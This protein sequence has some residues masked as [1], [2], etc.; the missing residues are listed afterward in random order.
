MSRPP[1]PRSNEKGAVVAVM[2]ALLLLI[3]VY[4]MFGSVNLAAVRVD[5]DRVTNETLR[6]AKEALIAY[7]VADPNRPGELPCPDV[8]NDGQ[9][10]VAADYVGSNC[11][12]LIG[13]LPFMTLGLPDLRDDSG[14]RLWYAVSDDF[15]ANGTVAL[16][17]DTA[18]RAG[19]TSLRITG[20]QSAN[21]LVAI[22]FAPGGVLQREGA[23]G[24][25]D[26]GAGALVAANYLDRIAGED[27]S[28][29]NRTFVAGPKSDSFNDKLMPIHSDEIMWLVERRAGRELTQHLRDQFDAWQTAAGKGFYPWAAPFSD[30]TT[31]QAGVANTLEGLLPLAPAPLVW[32][33][34]SAGCA[35]VGTSAI[36][37]T[38]LV[39]PPLIPALNING[40]IGNIGR[41]FFE[42]PKTTPPDVQVLGGLTLLGAPVATW[43]VNAPA[44]ALNFSYNAPGLGVGLVTVQVTAP[45]VSTWIGSSWLKDNHWYEVAY[46]GVAAPFTITGAGSCGSCITVTNT[47]LPGNKE[48]LVVMTGRALPGQ[49]ARP[50]TPPAALNQFLENQ[51]STSGDQTYEANVKSTTFND[52]PVVVRP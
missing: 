6:R 47:A 27:N 31:M 3:G 8:N 18:F 39:A 20:M 32:T 43:T 34:A 49:A 4:F 13:R 36:T 2:V 51:N 10:T 16:N 42:A 7:A 52:L 26:R 44:Q 19:N 24:L 48:A 29:G 17:N 33:A 38:G 35:G 14:E 40:T 5:R 28:D 1:R 23:V 50:L 21:N 46:Y 45:A 37:C 41:G 22:V 9:V 15:H 12:S 30:P 25:Q 11:A